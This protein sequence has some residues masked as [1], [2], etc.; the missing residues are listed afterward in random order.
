MGKLGALKVAIGTGEWKPLL[1]IFLTLGSL[2]CLIAIIVAFTKKIDMMEKNK[3][4][5]EEELKSY[6]IKYGIMGILLLIFGLLFL[7]V[8]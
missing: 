4:L 2:G 1:G 7:F 6:A 3:P 8:F 5:K